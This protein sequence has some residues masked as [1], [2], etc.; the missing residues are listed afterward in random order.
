MAEDLLGVL[1][2]FHREVVVPDIERIVDARITPLRDEM[3]SNFDAVFKRL[4]GLETEYYALTAAV[5]RLEQRMAA[6]EQK[7]DKFALRSELIELKQRVQQL[8]ERIAEL[9]AEL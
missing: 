3:L 1:T 6:I 9:E 5:G 2:R 8:E 4:D 7:I